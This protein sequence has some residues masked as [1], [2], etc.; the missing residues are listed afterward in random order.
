MANRYLITG[1]GNVVWTAADTGIWSDSSGGATGASVPGVDDDVI[2]DASSGGGKVTLGDDISVKSITMGAFTGEFDASTY[3]PTMQT[4][5]NT[6]TGTRT[7]SPGSGT[8]TITGNNATVFA[9]TTTTNLTISANTA[10]VDFNYSGSTGTRTININTSGVSGRWNTI[11]IS[12]GT[13]IITFGTTTC[14]NLD[15]TGFTG[16]VTT[17][18]TSARNLNGYLTLG[19][20]MTYGGTGTGVTTF[21]STT[22]TKTITS[23]GVALNFSITFDGV[24]GTWQLADALSTT[25]TITLTNGTFNA[26]NKNVTCSVFSSSNSNT[27]V[28]TMGSG[29]WTLTGTGTVWNTATT[30]NLTFNKDTAN[31][32]VTDEATA[33]GCTFSGGSKAYNGLWFA[34][35]AS[36]E[37]NTIVGDNSFV[38]LQ[39][40]GSEAHSL[41]FTAGSTTR[42]DNF[43][44][45]GT[46]GK[47]ITLNSTTTDV[48]NLISNGNIFDRD[49]LNIQHSV[50][51]PDYHWYA[52]T[53]SVDNQ[54]DETAGSGWI[55]TVKPL[56]VPGEMLFTT[57]EC[58]NIL[59]SKG[60]TIQGN[61]MTLTGHTPTSA[62]VVTP[63]SVKGGVIRNIDQATGD[64]ARTTAGWIE[65]EKYG[66]YFRV[67]A[68]GVSG[69]FDTAI[70]RTG[71]K[72]IKVSTTDTAGR[73]RAII[74]G[75]LGIDAN[76]TPEVLTK[77]GVPV[78]ASTVYRLRCYV[79][80]NNVASD[81][82]YLDYGFWDVAGTKTSGALTTNKLSGT[83][84]WTP[85]E[86]T[87]TT[88]ATTA[89]A[90]IRFQNSV[91]GNISDAWF[92]INSMTL[93]EVSTITNPLPYA[94]KFYPKGTAVSSTDNIDQ[95]QVSGGVSLEFG[96]LTQKKKQGQQI[97]PTKKYLTGVVIQKVASTGTYTG[98]VVVTLQGDS[99]DTPDGN[100]LSTITIPNATWEGLTNSA[101]YTVALNSTLT[102]GSKY[103]I[104]L[105]SSTNDDSNHPNFNFFA[106]TASYAGITSTFVSSWTTR[107]GDFYFKTLYSK[108]T[109]NMTV[110]TD[111]ETLSVTAPTVEGWA[112]GTV[113]DS[114]IEQPTFQG[115]TLAPGANTFYLSS[116]GSDLADG[117]TD[118]SLQVTVSGLLGTSSY[119][120]S[121]QDLANIWAETSGLS[122][123]DAINVKAGTTGRDI[124]SALNKLIDGI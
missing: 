42:V 112:N 89:Y 28:L 60:D 104:V 105:D 22:G 61:L 8:W 115:F 78:K 6:S 23:N 39:D 65:D 33:A 80:T 5:S 14:T 79:K 35:G 120:A 107:T 84:D 88:P 68:N 77:Y 30:T 15:F 70:T 44:I 57:Q 47:L 92:D 36:T 53:H 118:E 86:S 55:F 67:A 56:N 87:F 116:N 40:T 3:S 91:A 26:N 11:K 24:G 94:V 58:L 83:N 29:T 121:I 73:G 34:R 90:S 96:M 74:G 113:I 109:T 41:L 114:A 4:F 19:S 66:I 122:T 63:I 82:A 106:T 32:K 100:I 49:Y 18:T 52:G 54:D 119:D 93:E 12:A 31:I 9:Q 7:L 59:A 111:T 43:P 13:D 75:T 51:T 123:Q 20:G 21:S 1:G 62:S 48:F 64:I 16:T 71:S 69:E 27:R 101:D 110:R 95:S 117:E 37:S 50:A 2:M 99:T 102:I 108:N 103:W 25:G 85:V 17:I 124:Q 46:A 38:A 97:I 81:S 10:T 98:N 45:S 72:T 76:S